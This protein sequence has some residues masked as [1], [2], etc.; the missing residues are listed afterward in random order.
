MLWSG[1]GD[2]DK[3]A[4]LPERVRGLLAALLGVRPAAPAV[5]LGRVRLRPVALP[6]P[7][8]AGLS[9]IAGRDHVR[10]DDETRVRHTRGKSTPDLLKIRA[11]DGSDAPDAVVLPGSHEEVAA[12]LAYSSAGR[13]AVVPFG[14]GTSVVGGL[15]AAGHGFAGVVALDLSRMNRL[16][17]LD[18]TSMIAELEPGVRAADAE[19]MLAGHGL[20]L[21]HFPQSYEYA[22]LGGFAAARS[23]G[24]ASAGY[25][26]FDDMVMGMTVATPT[27]T[28]RLGRAPRSAAGPDLRQLVL[29]S[30][31]AFGV[32]TSL[33]LRVRR[34]PAERVYEGWRFV[35]FA[36]GAAALR[37]LAQRGPLPAVLRLSDET[38]TMA[39]QAMSEGSGDPEPEG[40]CLAIAGYEGTAEDVRPVR[41]RVSAAL[42]GFGGVPLGEGPGE[43]WAAG[44]F[45]APYLR[46]SLL[47]AGATAETLETAAFWSALPGLYQEVRRALQDRLG[48][49]LVMCH[50]SHVYETGASLYF[51][52]V[53]AQDDDPVAQWERAKEAACQAIGRAGGTISHHHGVG[54]DHREAYAEE[55]GE[56]GVAVIRAVKDRLD[57][58]GVLNPG[59]LLA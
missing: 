54:R 49:A 32:I 15:T 42:S 59:V 39:G 48:S 46:D 52:V 14:G 57:P 34:A 29:G 17:A 53:T 2:P 7:L 28:L 1:W 38:E 51:T 9:D 13:I 23:S 35:S 45:A 16:S 40:G 25:G 22:T 26:R 27:G 20:T 18:T 36:E 47:G 19:R 6:A 5:P 30:E 4:D 10:L 44:R 43:S 33:R 3:A 24:Q 8:L 37:H 12:L 11:G 50:I 21:G 56:L 55:I 58:A 41:E 31:G